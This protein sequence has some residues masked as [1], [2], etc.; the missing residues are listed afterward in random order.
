[1]GIEKSLPYV[2]CP[3][4]ESTRT[5]YTFI[6]H[7]FLSQVVLQ[8]L[9]CVFFVIWESESRILLRRLYKIIQQKEKEEKKFPFVSLIIIVIMNLFIYYQHLDTEEMK[10]EVKTTL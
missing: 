2:C 8:S 10:I 5:R 9:G 1:M 4:L 6:C 3:S 7:H